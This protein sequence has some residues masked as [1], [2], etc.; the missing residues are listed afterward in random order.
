VGGIGANKDAGFDA[1]N[2]TGSTTQG[3]TAT[4]L[5][6]IPAGAVFTAQIGQGSGGNLALV[7][8]GADCA[9]LAVQWLG[10]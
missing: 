9:S 5:L 4:Q 8:N 2:G 7:D 3:Q 6:H 1:R 10:P